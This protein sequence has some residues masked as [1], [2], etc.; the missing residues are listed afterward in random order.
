MEA[1]EIAD[2]IGDAIVVAQAGVVDEHLDMLVKRIEKLEHSLRTAPMPFRESTLGDEDWDD[3]Y[4]T[5]WHMNAS[6]DGLAT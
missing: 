1:Q 4:D 6:E 3:Y 5:W 2:R